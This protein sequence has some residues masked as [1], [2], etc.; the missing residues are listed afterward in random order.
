MQHEIETGI[1]G[2]LG[3]KQHFK[4]AYCVTDYSERCFYGT[5]NKND[6]YIF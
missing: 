2:G 5:P 4:T 3:G 1:L 6:A